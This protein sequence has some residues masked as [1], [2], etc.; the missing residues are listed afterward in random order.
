MEFKD[1][2]TTYEALLPLREQVYLPLVK[3][4]I[5]ASMKIRA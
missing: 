4:P 1:N 3:Y 2:Y 5:F